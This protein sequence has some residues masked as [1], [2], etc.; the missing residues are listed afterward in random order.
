MEGPRIG[1]FRLCVV[2]REVCARCKAQGGR[3]K[4]FQRPRTDRRT[5]TSASP[6]LAS[7][8]PSTAV[9][10]VLAGIVHTDGACTCQ[11]TVCPNRSQ[12]LTYLRALPRVSPSSYRRYGKLRCAVHTGGMLQHAFLQDP[13]AA[14]PTHYRMRGNCD[15]VLSIRIWA[16][17]CIAVGYTRLPVQNERVMSTQ[18]TNACLVGRYCNVG[19]C[20]TIPVDGLVVVA[21]SQSQL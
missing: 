12:P 4:Y 3:N 5:A 2:S 19:D 9:V 20:I 1:P 15:T 10:S 16:R 7:T 17:R 13:A 11:A 14:R 8:D 18:T 21:R 6:A